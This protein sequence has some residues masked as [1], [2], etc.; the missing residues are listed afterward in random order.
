VPSR[1][2]N[3]PDCVILFTHHFTILKEF[4]MATSVKLD[5]ELKNRIQRLA[6]TH[7]RSAHLIMRAAIREYVEREEAKERFKQDAL[8]SWAVYQ[9]TGKHLTGQEVCDWLN[10]WGT[11]KET[12]APPPVPRIIITEHAAR[13]LE[14]CRR[15]LAEK[16][17]RAARVIHEHGIS[18]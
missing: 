4:T 5:D 6:D 14:R 13:G 10:T 15:F 9:E 12:E 1:K 7:Q 8:T 18:T 17:P 11:D 16:N 2:Y 3:L